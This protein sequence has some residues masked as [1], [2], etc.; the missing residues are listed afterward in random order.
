MLAR[1]STLALRATTSNRRHPTRRGQVAVR[2][3]ALATLLA[4]LLGTF[5]ATASGAVS[6]AHVRGEVVTL[7]GQQ[8]V[9][10]AVVTLPAF[11]IHTVS[12]SDGRFSFTQ[13][14]PAARP[15]RRIEAVVRA[16][17][18][19]T[20]T[21]KGAPLYPGDTLLLHAQLSASPYTDVVLTPDERM[22]AERTH[23]AA[24]VRPAPKA[25]VTCTGWDNQLVPPPT[26]SV[27]W[28]GSA[29]TY[30]FH[31]YVAHV[32]PKEWIPSWDADALGAGAIAVKS[33]GWYRAQ[34]GHA[35]TSGAG[36]V[37]IYSTTSDQVFDPNYTT[38]ATEQAVNATFGSILHRSGL[39]FSTQY[40][41]GVQGDPCRTTD[42]RMDQ[43]ATQTCAL[44][45][46]LWP[47]ITTT[48]YTSTTFAYLNYLLLNPG[49]E[50]SAMYP[51]SWPNVTTVTRN[52]S[53]SN[54]GSWSLTVASDR[55]ASISQ[56]VPFAGTSSTAYH[57]FAAFRCPPTNSTVC[58]ITTRLVV[59]GS[60][61]DV[62]IY[63]RRVKLPND[64]VWQTFAFDTPNA[65]LDHT[66][67]RVTFVSPYTF[68]LD[69]ALLSAPFG[70]P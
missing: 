9:A 29:H 46:K 23:A 24:P 5:P 43:W 37:D 38:A 40:Y 42:G 13:A 47:G 69:S 19:G 35:R 20:W 14:L 44:A 31:F 3:I 26:I 55:A 21:I 36:C 60:S 64:G 28:D 12:A 61:G 67:A 68:G 15:Y 1:A 16:S 22:A 53:T 52:S 66:L 2:A 50:S 45:G 6:T 33:Y 30:D 4:A 27:D 18:W 34:P 57:I 63:H 54:G 59:T 58:P 39:I 70:G 7:D 51:W 48:F 41:A 65:G 8:P 49:A 11:G 17:G 25:S 32:L 62:L 56:T 10:G